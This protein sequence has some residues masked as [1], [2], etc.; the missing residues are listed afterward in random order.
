ML[1]DSHCH[2][3][4]ERFRED[5]DAVLTRA[6]AAGVEAMVTIGSDL[7]DSRAAVALAGDH[8]AVWAA[9]GIHPHV[10]AAAGEG[11][12]E[13]EVL[14]AGPRVVA[15]G[16]TGLDYHYDHS[17]RTVQRRLFEAHLAL[18]A[19]TSLPVVVHTR[20]ADEDA[21]AILRSAPAA[22][23]GVL[24]CFTAG[25]AL[26]DAALERSWYISFAGV[27]TFRT[28]DG[29]E[30]LRRVPPDRLL[31]ETDSPYLAPVPH[32][33]RRNEPAFVAE[34]CSAAAAALGEE[35][36]V[37]AARTVANARRFFRL[38]RPDTSATG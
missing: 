12:G 29:L 6:A 23:T 30:R 15:I 32:R 33:G 31:V 18:A 7:E 4:D 10:A 13:I 27:I 2:L 8:A 34:V 36:D 28:W 16:E 5:L 9:V 20:D 38:G 21:V 25:D 14:A 26:L 35:V 11:M 3:T 1:I 17:P 19:T 37:V 22:V 24:H